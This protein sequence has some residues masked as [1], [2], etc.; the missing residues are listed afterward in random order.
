M[1]TLIPLV[2]AILT[3]AGWWKIFEKS[4]RQGWAILVPIYNV[5][6]MIDIAEKPMWWLFLLLIPIVNIFVVASIMI[7]IAEKFGKGLGYGIGMTFLSFVFVPM[8]AF[9]DDSYRGGGGS[10]L[11]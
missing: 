7:A 9:G 10:Y 2:L 1:R 5:I 8:L 4:G 11:R 3:I 6:V